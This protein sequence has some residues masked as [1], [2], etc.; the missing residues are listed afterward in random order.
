MLHH[1]VNTIISELVLLQAQLLKSDIVLEHFTE[2]DGDT[3][4]D[5]PVDGVVD[6][7]LLQ[8]EVA[9]VEHGQDSNDTI[10][11]NFVVA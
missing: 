7:E 6:V 8:R 1:D 2:V 4:A 3:L 11:V 5:G 10:V 9:R